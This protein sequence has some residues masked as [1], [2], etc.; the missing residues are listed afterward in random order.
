MEGVS[1]GLSWPDANAHRAWQPL[2]EERGPGA[3]SSPPIRL[4]D[5]VRAAT[6]TRHYSIAYQRATPTARQQLALRRLCEVLVRN[7]PEPRATT[8]GSRSD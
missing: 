1:T 8:R 7:D 6:R 2:R 3:E 5:R 4:L